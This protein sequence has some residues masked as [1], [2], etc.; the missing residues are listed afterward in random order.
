M[1]PY[2]GRELDPGKKKHNEELSKGRVSIECSFGILCARWQVFQNTMSVSPDHA[3]KIIM[4]AILLH[5]YLML[6]DSRNQYASAA[7]VADEWRQITSTC[8]STFR[9]LPPH[10]RL[11]ARNAAAES[12][13]IREKIKNLLY[14]TVT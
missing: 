12:I 2:S 10:M 5:N 8:N 6:G 3:D 7:F 13:S 14:P 9:A 11:G 1:T 4:A